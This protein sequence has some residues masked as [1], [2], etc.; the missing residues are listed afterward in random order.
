MGRRL[1]IYFSLLSPWAYIGHGELRRLA[2]KHALALDFRPVNLMEVFTKS[3]GLPLPKRHPS[4]QAYRMIELQRWRERRGLNFD[5]RPRFW[6]FGP[7]AADRVICA[8]V[9]EGADPEKSIAG[10]FAAISSRTATWPTKAKSP[11]C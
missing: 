3:G 9:A 11:P 5:L 6:P 4:R 2:G 7:R 1:T 10:A 8:M